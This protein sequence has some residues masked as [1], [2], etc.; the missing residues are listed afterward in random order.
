MGSML[1]PAKGRRGSIKRLH[2][3]KIPPDLLHKKFYIL[4][5]ISPGFS[6][7]LFQQEG[8]GVIGFSRTMRPQGRPLEPRFNLVFTANGEKDG[9]MLFIT[10]KKL[11]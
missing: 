9:S 6:T 2:F 1:A 7:M 10:L 3:F 5:I 8:N 11:L 4:I